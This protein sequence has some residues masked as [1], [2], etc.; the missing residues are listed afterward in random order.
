MG[1]TVKE[2]LRPNNSLETKCI[3]QAVLQECLKKNVTIRK[4]KR[5]R[6]KE[7]KGKEKRKK[8]KVCQNSTTGF[9]IS[10]RIKLW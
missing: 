2:F 5:K 9:T 3:S 7:R 4:T 8:I 1:G 6:K 10:T